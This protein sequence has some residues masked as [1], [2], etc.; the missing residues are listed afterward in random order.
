MARWEPDAQGRLVKAAMELFSEHGYEQ[1]TVAEI[2]ERAGLT[3][4]T[5]FRHY[6]DKREV[7]FSGGD[8]FRDAFVGRLEEALDSMSALQAVTIAAQAAGASLEERVGRD[9]ASARQAIVSVNPALREREL[10]KIADITA[11]M[12]QALR[13]RGVDEPDASM[14]AELG[15][16]GFRVGFDRWL[17]AGEQRTLP[18]LIHE[19]LGR[20]PSVVGS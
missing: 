12:A 1:T 6:S 9:F 15:M 18:G 19:A 7:L 4:R 3:E 2:A 20:I 8:E 17:A 13:L 11:A 14:T 16:A 10:I 5:F